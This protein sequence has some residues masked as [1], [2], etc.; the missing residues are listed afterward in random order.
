MTLHVEDMCGAVDADPEP[1]ADLAGA[2]DGTLFH[3]QCLALTEVPVA[4]CGGCVHYA[5]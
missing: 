3:S 4:T 5:G 2:A 1:L